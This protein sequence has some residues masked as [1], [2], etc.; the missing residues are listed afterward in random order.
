MA[1]TTE[2]QTVAA[3]SPMSSG[4]GGRSSAG[5]SRGERAMSLAER[6]GMAIPSSAD[7]ATIM[8]PNSQIGEREAR[9]RAKDAG[10]PPNESTRD[11]RRRRQ[12]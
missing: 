9:R 6:R 12:A 10:S 7:A 1:P 5:V 3:I 4:G 8:R 11:S 2:R